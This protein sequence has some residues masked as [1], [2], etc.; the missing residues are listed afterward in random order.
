VLGSCTNAASVSSKPLA[1]MYRY[2]IP[3]SLWRA[4]GRG[5][6]TD[7]T[8][9]EGGGGESCRVSGTCARKEKKAGGR[10]CVWACSAAASLTH[11]DTWQGWEPSA[12]DLNCSSSHGT[13]PP[14][15]PGA[16]VHCC[17]R[18]RHR[19]HCR[20]HRHHCRRRRHHHH[21]RLPCPTTVR[22]SLAQE[23]RASAPLRQL[24]LLRP[25]RA[26]D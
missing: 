1:S 10:E 16:C 2:T 14:V 13:R 7:G 18:H 9:A 3:C 23:A 8:R 25:G 26:R 19:H 5:D 17:H 4:V 20:R 12:L 11:L 22:A 24:A 6:G 21:R 15:P